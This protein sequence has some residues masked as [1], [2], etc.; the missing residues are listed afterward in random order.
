M[1]IER[2]YHFIHPHTQFF[3]R[4]ADNTQIGL[5]RHQPVQRAAIQII[6]LQRFINDVSQFGNRNLEDFITRHS[7]IGRLVLILTIL[8][9][10]GQQT[11]VAAVGVQM[12]RQNARL[13]RSPQ[14]HRACAITKQNDSAAIFRIQRA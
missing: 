6:G 10:Q 12:G 13:F 14:Q 9:R 4:R 8:E 1:T 5:V 3:R 7:D 2:H 11:A